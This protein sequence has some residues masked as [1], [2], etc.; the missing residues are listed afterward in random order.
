MTLCH[1]LRNLQARGRAA[2]DAR[3]AAA[4]GTED[5]IAWRVPEPEA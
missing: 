1:F 5:A 4:D 2:I 3:H